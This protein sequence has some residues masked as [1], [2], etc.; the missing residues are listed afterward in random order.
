MSQQSYS[1]CFVNAVVGLF[2]P[3]GDGNTCSNTL[4]CPSSKQIVGLFTTRGEGNRLAIGHKGVGRER[5]VGPFIPKRSRAFTAVP[6]RNFYSTSVSC[7]TTVRRRPRGSCGSALRIRGDDPETV[8][9][10]DATVNVY[11]S[12]L[13][14]AY[15]I[16]LAG[17]RYVNS[18]GRCNDADP[19]GESFG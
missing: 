10:Y 15:D 2:T 16:E 8:D 9:S 12:L 14:D 18:K 11:L 19:N 13:G 1:A 5:V 3:R 4:M 7:R 17:E 6:S